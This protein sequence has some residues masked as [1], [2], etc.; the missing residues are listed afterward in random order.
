VKLDDF[1]FGGEKETERIAAKHHSSAEAESV[2]NKAEEKAAEK[3]D[4]EPV[5]ENP[6]TQID[7]SY[8]EKAAKLIDGDD[9]GVK[10]EPAKP[11]KQAAQPVKTTAQPQRRHRAKV[12]DNSSIEDLMKL[13]DAEQQKLKN[14]TKE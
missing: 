14:K 10:A 2:Q 4:A 13:M 9:S 7:S 3:P 5:N 1:L 12:N 8:Y 11:V 6:K